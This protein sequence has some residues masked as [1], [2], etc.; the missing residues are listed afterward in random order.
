MSRCDLEIHLDQEDASCRGG[1]SLEGKVVV[2]AHKECSCTLTISVSWRTRGRG[3]REKGTPTT[4]PLFQGDWYPGEERSYPFRLALPPGPGSYSGHLFG[5]QW[6]LEARA[7][8]ALGRDETAEKVITLVPPE[9]ELYDFGPSHRTTISG[10]RQPLS[11]RVLTGRLDDSAQER[12]RPILLVTL[13]SLAAVLIF[14]LAYQIRSAIGDRTP[15]DNELPLPVLL[16]PSLGLILLLGG[17]AIVLAAW[18]LRRMVG[19][20]LGTPEVVW[21]SLPARRGEV[22]AVEMFLK[23]RGNVTLAEVSGVLQVTEGVTEMNVNLTGRVRKEDTVHPIYSR[24]VLL[25]RGGRQVRRG[26]QVHLQGSWEIP[27]SAPLTFTAKEHRV[28]WKV[29]MTIGIRRWPDWK[30]EYGITVGPSL[31]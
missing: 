22:L 2:R 7:G 21:N 6:V 3:D 20:K 29:V 30:R 19:M 8:V 24:T 5:V 9:G 31:G 16:H 4:E 26:E 23:P 1:G 11:A 10:D 14:I 15:G 17:L 12:P 28:E 25:L 13:A 27:S 18:L